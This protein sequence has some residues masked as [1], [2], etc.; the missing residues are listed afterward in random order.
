MKYGQ[1]TSVRP[2]LCPSVCVFVVV[3]HPSIRPCIV[4]LFINPSVRSLLSVSSC[5]RVLDV[6]PLTV[7]TRNTVGLLV[8]DCECVILCRFHLVTVTVSTSTWMCNIGLHVQT[9]ITLK[10]F[11]TYECRLAKIHNYTVDNVLLWHLKHF[12]CTYVSRTSGKFLQ[13]LQT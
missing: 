10:S 3:V 13:L 2:P 11:T 6:R 9:L 4:S 1:N 5:V 8:T 12:E 7:N